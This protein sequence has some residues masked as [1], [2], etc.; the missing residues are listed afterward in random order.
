MIAAAEG[1]GFE[2][3][4]VESLREHYLTTLRHWVR[5]L[6]AHESEARAATGDVTYRVWRLYMAAAAHGFRVGRISVIQS[7]L[8]KRDADGRVSTPRT[9]ADLYR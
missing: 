7:L 6:E 5:R 3:R 1:Q 2:V 9:R 8:G 4:D